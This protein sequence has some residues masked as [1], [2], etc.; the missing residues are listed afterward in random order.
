M[1]LLAQIKHLSDSSFAA[2]H[3]LH[4]FKGYLFLGH[5]VY[6]RVPKIPAR[7]WREI[8]TARMRRNLRHILL[9]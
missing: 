7:L 8:E 2:L 1:S 4:I 9:N 3:C 5:N 6:Q